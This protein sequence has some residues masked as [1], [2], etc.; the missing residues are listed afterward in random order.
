MLDFLIERPE[1]FCHLNSRD[2][3]QFLSHVPYNSQRL[4]GSM[5]RFDSSLH[6]HAKHESEVLQR[7]PTFSRGFQQRYVYQCLAKKYL[8][9]VVLRRI[10]S[11][12][13]SVSHFNFY[14][15]A[16]YT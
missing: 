5:P 1:R 4:L 16:D 7:L 8:R 10:T 13:I 15:H 14:C 2:A 9:M 3:P 12:F 6:F 11:G